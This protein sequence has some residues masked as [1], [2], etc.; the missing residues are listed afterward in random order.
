MAAAPGS[1]VHVPDSQ[2]LALGGELSFY[3]HFDGPGC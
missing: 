3:S 2:D 1:T